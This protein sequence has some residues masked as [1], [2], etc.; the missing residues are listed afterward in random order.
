M[1]MYAY[2]K[3]SNVQ[4]EKMQVN[5]VKL[6][7]KHIRDRTRR[8]KQTSY[9]AEQRDNRQA[10]LLIKQVFIRYIQQQKQQSLQS[11][12]N[13]GRLEMKPNKKS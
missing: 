8:R 4:R 9:R 12:I 7:P 10:R 1:A 6:S 11:Q 3:Y 13:W 5:I 2:T